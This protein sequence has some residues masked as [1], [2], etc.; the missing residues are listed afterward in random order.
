MTKL[1][2]GNIPYLDGWRGLAI[3]GVL[4]SHF[5][6][7]AVDWMGQF[8]VQLFFVL[9][10]YLM[11]GLLFIKHVRLSDFFVRR[12]SRVFP[13][14]WVFVAAMAVYA[15]VQPKPY[16]V[17][18]SEIAAVLTFTR[19]YLGETNIWA[20]EW[21]IGHVWSLSV[22]EHSYIFLAAGAFMVRGKGKFAAPAFLALSVLMVLAVIIW[23]QMHPPAGLSPWY[24]RS[25]VAALG[26]LGAACYRV[27]ADRMPWLRKSHPILALIAFLVALLAYS[28]YAHKGLQYTLAPLCLAYVINHLSGAPAWIHAALSNK[29]LRWFGL[30][31][32]SLYLWQQPFY[33][34]YEM[35]GLPLVPALVL[36]L[37]TGAISFYVLENP[38]RLYLNRKW[39]ERGISKEPLAVPVPS[40]SSI[41]DPRASDTLAAAPPGVAN[42]MS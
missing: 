13:T 36:A 26:L 4:I 3:I 32:F 19:T 27:S 15:S 20:R 23:Y 21:A 18:F 30:C 24:V 31:S 41:S 9:S 42:T 14:L 17:T 25:E 6:L 10:G 7:L 35:Y 40:A 11:G 8:G 34:A 16:D 38:V 37:V 2:T 29:V 12:I 39:A 33:Y 28:I 22:E 1:G 5:D